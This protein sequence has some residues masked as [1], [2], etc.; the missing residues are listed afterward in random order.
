DHQ[1]KRTPMKTTLI[2]VTLLASSATFLNAAILAGPVTNPTNG[3]KYYLLTED[4]W[5]NSE[6]QAIGLGGHLVTINDQAEQDWVFSTFGT[7]AGTT[8]SLWI[9]LRE[10][11]SEGNYEWVSGEPVTYTHWCCNQPDNSGGNES[12]VHMINIGNIYGHPGGGW[13]DLD[14]PNT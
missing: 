8:R 10:V 4:T 3:H 9:G 13:N 14:S 5:Q 1:Q 11:G 7:Y 12:Y 2:I 6:S